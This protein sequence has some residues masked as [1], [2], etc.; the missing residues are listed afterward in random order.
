MHRQND[1]RLLPKA[2]GKEF[3]SHTYWG[4]AY[5]GDG[6][7]FGKSERNT[8]IQH[9]R[10]SSKHP[11]S[12]ISTTPILENARDYATHVGRHGFIYKIDTSLLERYEVTAYE[13]SEHA[14]Q[15][16][17]PGDREVILVAKDFG[18]LPQEIVVEIIEISL[19]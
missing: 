8:V 7:V 15:P 16:K 4:D 14:V 9:Q 3:R 17:I 12:G 18:E 10:D 11:T 19:P 1:G 5:W 2:L 13:V 6:S